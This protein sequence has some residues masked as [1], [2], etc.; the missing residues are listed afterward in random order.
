MRRALTMALLLACACGGEDEPTEGEQACDELEDK[1]AECRLTTNGTCNEDQPCVVRCAIDA[2]CAQLTMSPPTGS[3][4][5]CV[6]GCSGAGPDD[7][8][9]MDGRGF[10]AKTGMCDGLYQCMDGSDEADCGTA[11]NGMP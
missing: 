3:Y 1:L 11:G 10:V 8:I 9:C 5:A 2:D 7:F 4:L 6:A